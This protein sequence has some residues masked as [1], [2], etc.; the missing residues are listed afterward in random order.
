M[1]TQNVII[2]ASFPPSLANQ[3]K[4][5]ECNSPQMKNGCPQQIKAQC[6]PIEKNLEKNKIIPNNLHRKKT[7]LVNST[8]YAHTHST[9]THT[10]TDG[11][12]KAELNCSRPSRSHDLS[13]TPT[14]GL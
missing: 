1:A 6:S 2:V 13:R 3:T 12:E 9:H 14:L 10:H 4:N 11:N 8:A 7:A 5:N